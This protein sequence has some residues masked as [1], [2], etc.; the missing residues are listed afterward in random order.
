MIGP[1]ARGRFLGLATMENGAKGVALAFVDTLIDDRLHGAVALEHGP[2]P[3]VNESGVEACQIDLAEIPLMRRTSKPWQWP[4][5][6]RSSNWQGQP[7]FSCSCRIRLLPHTN[8]S[9][10]I[11]PF[12]LS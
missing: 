11:P 2:G 6:G 4:W 1:P 5:V 12:W 10:D 3:S 7:Y 8:R 9:L